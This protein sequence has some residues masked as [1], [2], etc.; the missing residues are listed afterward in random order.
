MDID[1][2]RIAQRIKLNKVGGSVVHH[3]AIL[4]KYLATRK[5]EARVVHGYCISPNEICEH[6]WVR[7]EPEGLNLDIGY[8]IACLYSP[9]LL[10]LNTVLLEDFPVGLKDK[11]GKEPEILRQE[12]NQRIFELYE[13]GPKTFWREAPMTVKTFSINKCN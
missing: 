7:T 6:Y 9:E 1:L 3:C 4:M 13:T 2:K 12:D 11:E 10:A 8:E 5:I